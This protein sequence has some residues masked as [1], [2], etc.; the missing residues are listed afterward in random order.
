MIEI[1]NWQGTFENADTRKRQRLKSIHS[2]TGVDSRGLVNL[3]CHFDQKDALAAFGVFQMLCQLSGTHPADLRG[4]LVHTCGTPMTEDYL[5]RLMRIEKCHLSAALHILEDQRVAWIS[6]NRPHDDL[7][8]SSCPSPGFVQGEGEVEG[9]VPPI[10]PQGGQQGD[11][12]L[13]LEAEATP[14]KTCLPTGWKKMKASDQRKRRVNFNTPSMIEIGKCFGRSAETRWSVYEAVA[15]KQ[16]NP[17]PEEVELLLWFYNIE[18]PDDEDYR[19]KNL[20]TMLNN[21]TGE[22]DRARIYKAQKGIR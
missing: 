12:K 21:L 8:P 6:R 2:P 13:K 17:T 4:R 1:T 5:A 19:R 22:L 11:G 9:E 7:P 10:A 18:I 15:L 16:A 14:K 20:E 3:L